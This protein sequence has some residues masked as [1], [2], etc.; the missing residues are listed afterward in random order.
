M[1]S[2]LEVKGVWFLPDRS[3]R[4]I[5]G[6]LKYS[7]DERPTLELDGLLM[8]NAQNPTDLPDY[9]FILGIADNGDQI[10]L[11][12]C[13]QM[14]SIGNTFSVFACDFALIG[15]HFKNT[16]DLQ[17][18]RCQVEFQHL[19][20][21][22]GITGFKTD[23]L[24]NPSGVN[25]IYEL[26]D[27]A[28]LASSEEYEISIFT[29][30]S[31]KYPGNEAIIKQS[32][33]VIIDFT[34]SMK[35]EALL[36]FVRTIQ[37]FLTL[38]TCATPFP[39]SVK[40]SPE[41]P[42]LQRGR[43]R[44]ESISVYYNPVNAYSESFVSRHNMLFTYKD[45]LPNSSS[46]INRWI[47]SF[48]NLQPVYNLYFSNIYSSSMYI[49]NKFLNLTQ[50]IETYHRRVHGGKYQDD[51]NYLQG[52]YNTLVQALPNNLDGEFRTSLVKGKLRYANEYSLRKRLNDL[53]RSL[54]DSLPENFLSNDQQR[55]IFVSKTT[56]TRNYLTHYDESSKSNAVEG[57]GI[58]QLEYTL[59]LILEACFLIEIGFYPAVIRAML[60]KSDTY[61]TI[62]YLERQ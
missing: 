43:L 24:H 10:T 50:A 53:I 8:L 28:V 1:F 58:A 12:R 18:K 44:Y 48:S 60:N 4:R 31:A 2:E 19:T 25:I 41:K 57:I 38:A 6:K 61:R 22:T 49:E 14:R 30:Y 7:R 36:Q 20:E 34:K 23:L 3:R 33:S 35:I 17:F 37:Y 11:W 16:N 47:K 29:T 21:W 54:N 56:D 15:N 45:L 42:R 13:I 55:N 9:E 27:T 5:T 62:Q 32:A 46:M 59:R 40:V 26:P 39:L 51:T 52:L